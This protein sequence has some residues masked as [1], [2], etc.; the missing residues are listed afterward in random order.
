MKSVMEEIEKNSVW[1]AGDA[2]APDVQERMSV[3]KVNQGVIYYI[4]DYYILA[5]DIISPSLDL[6][7]IMVFCDYFTAVFTRV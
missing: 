1:G 6:M 7:F 5:N 3:F 4:P 2:T